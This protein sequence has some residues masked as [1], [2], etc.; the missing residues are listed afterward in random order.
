MRDPGLTGAKEEAR[1]VEV[2]GLANES[3]NTP[4]VAETDLVAEM[5]RENEDAR[6]AQATRIRMAAMDSLREQY[7]E[8]PIP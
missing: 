4:I 6:Q 7:G 8:Q 3:S 1:E 2:P 5:S